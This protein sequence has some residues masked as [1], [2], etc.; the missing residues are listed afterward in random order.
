MSHPQAARWLDDTN[1]ITQTFLSAG[2]KPDLINLGGG[3]PEP[4][5]W[6]VDALADIAAEV[7][8]TD[9]LEALGYTPIEGL[10]ALRDAIAARFSTP[11]LQLTRRHVLITTGGLQA[12][13]IIGKALLDEGQCIATQTPVFL[14]ALDAWKP[15][16]PQ[17]R[18][19]HLG[20]PGFDPHAAMAGAQFGYVV[21]NFSNPSGRLVPVSERQHL[22]DAARATGTWLIEDDPYGALYFDGPALPSILTLDG[23]RNPG[24]YAGPVIYLGTVSKELAPGLRVGWIIAAP[25]LIDILITV[26]QG[27]DLCTSGLCQMIALRAYE[28]G[29]VERAMPGI[30]ST[31]RERR[32]A[33]CAALTRHLADE[34]DWEVPVGGMF[35]WAT[36]KD[37]AIDTARLLSFALDHGVCTAPGGV[38]DPTGADR[39]SMRISF[40]RNPPA[41]LDEGLRRLRLAIAAMR[42]S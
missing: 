4:A 22:L 28:R 6:P 38:F 18:Q 2:L 19:M 21:P 31:Y 16:R 27:S 10:P 7:I 40:T 17:Y 39:R 29:V 35:V 13:E 37:P 8:R 3:L 5:T 42:A 26:K 9:T 33:C 20:S 34:L 15:R 12:I 25:E 23:E 24:P 32:D 30:L 36:V 14:G 41:R 11:S 1:D